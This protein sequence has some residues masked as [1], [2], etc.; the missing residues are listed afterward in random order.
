MKRRHFLQAAAALGLSQFHIQR[1]GLRYAKA[2]AQP[3]ARKRALL[4][5]INK[6]PDSQR[7]LNLYGCAT[8]AEM[9]RQLL[10]HRFGFNPSDIVVVSD[11]SDL[12]PT[13]DN[14]LTAFEDH[15]IKPTQPGDV[16]VFHFSGHG[17]RVID[18]DPISADDLNSTF[19]PGDID[20]DT[21]TVDD[22]MGRTLFLLMSALDTDNVT[23]VLDSCYA[24]GGTRGNMR[25]RA[26]DG[27][28]TFNPSDRELNYQ[29]Q[30]L[31]KLEAAQG[32]DRAAFLKR[33]EVGVAKGIVIAAAQRNQTA[34]D[35]SFDGFDAGAFTYLMTQ[36][37]W[38]QTDS[39]RSTIAHV[40]SD[41][42]Q[43]SGQIPLIDPP[44]ADNTM[45]FVPDNEQPAPAEAVVTA[46]NGKAATIWLGGVHPDVIATF[47]RGSTLSVA[48]SSAG[49][50]P[51]MI[52]ERQ[53]LFAM[54]TTG[55]PLPESTPLRETARVIPTDLNLTIG[56]DPSLA[57]KANQ[58]AK[59]INGWS[60]MQAVIADAE[61]LYGTDVQLILS[62]M[63]A[64]YRQQLPQQVDLPA[65]NTI[66]LFD[67]GLTRWLPNTFTSGD[68]S[69]QSILNRLYPKL[70]S[71]LAAQF[72]RVSLN[73][74]TSQL[75]IYGEIADI[76]TQR[77]LTAMVSGRGNRPDPMAQIG[78][79]QIELNKTLRITVKNQDTAPLYIA[80]VGI[81]PSGDFAL[82]LPTNISST[83]VLSPGQTA[84]IPD[85]DVDQYDVALDIPGFHTAMVLASRTPF[86]R[87]LKG[88]SAIAQGERIKDEIDP[89]EDIT[90][91]NGLLE[92]FDESR[93]DQAQR[94][95]TSLST[96]NIAILAMTIEAIG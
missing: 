53:G 95:A 40:S 58:I 48:G 5:G 15:L 56:I 20:G 86:T 6:Y 89:N 91:L 88:L 54:A 7:F 24:G 22:I 92:G 77:L 73:A 50:A 49:N 16:V 23:A 38:Q 96:T 25:I 72:M 84:L 33:R 57:P 11:D 93:G 3:T 9:Q 8:D 79:A 29:E 59:R 74:S 69:M 75:A 13:R 41:I 67:Q 42:R 71:N 52:T 78:P 65:L 62:K 17:S 12:K 43:L 68:T 51:L 83:V 70:R 26:A 18:P 32:I 85:P 63:T 47:D 31:S 1:Q 90:G 61:G 39:L 45:Y 94:Q 10:I 55:E 35:V 19:V 60:H 44:A 87:T 64:A 37:L 36:F 14:I 28:Q 80:V 34:A 81:T 30:W 2:L 46:V 82:L 27:G 76:E 21:D 4:V 66:G